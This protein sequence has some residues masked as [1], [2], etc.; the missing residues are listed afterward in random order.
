[1]NG[2]PVG[3]ARM[4]STSPRV[5]HRVTIMTKVKLALRRT[6]PMMARGRVIDASL[7]SSPVLCQIRKTEESERTH[8][9]GAI[10]SDQDSNRCQKTDHGREAC[11][12]PATIV[13]EL[14][15]SN[16]DG[17]SWCHDPKRDNDGKESKNV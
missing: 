17:S 3:E 10:V 13:C 11:C 4:L 15:E 7:I 12:W 2:Y 16:L 6:D 5:K 9:N 1:M 14:K 8:M